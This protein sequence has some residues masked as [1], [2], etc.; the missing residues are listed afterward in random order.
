MRPMSAPPNPLSPAPAPL[1]SG[2]SVTQ[3][4]LRVRDLGRV[5]RFYTHVVGLDEIDAGRD[6]VWLGAGDVP[7]LQLVENPT[8]EPQTG[9]TGLFHLAIL[10]PSR[11]DL[12]AVTARLVGLQAPLQGASDHG[13]S[14]AVYFADPEGNGVEIYR[15]REMAEWPVQN[16]ELRMQTLHLDLPALLDEAPP[17]ERWRV[18]SGTRLGH[19]H[20]RVAD[21]AEAEAF[22]RDVVGLDLM[23]RYGGS[24]SFFSAGGYHHHVAVNTWASL[25]APAP[26]G[27][28]SGL[29]WFRIEA[30]D[31]A[32]RQRLI[33]RLDDHDRLRSHTDELLRA[34]DPSGNEVRI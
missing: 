22:Y 3:I 5:T 29:G 11:A 16:G 30:A 1:P 14:E 20:L 28:A 15:D 33:E 6:S 32:A 26:P 8:G 21:I 7:F 12:A 10:Y 31:P 19:V 4:S 9:A 25:G 17:A 27:D 13:V 23:Q 18:P 2:S 34:L 24:A